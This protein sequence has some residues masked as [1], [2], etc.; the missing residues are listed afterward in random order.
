MLREV[1]PQVTVNVQLG[2]IAPPRLRV[3]VARAYART[4]PRA[5][6]GTTLI[7]EPDLLL[8]LARRMPHN[9]TGFS[10]IHAPNER[11]LVKEFRNTVLAQAEFFQEFAERWG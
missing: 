4:Q 11:V 3:A 5:C 7:P 8:A 6:R 2:D 1:P 10:N 9:V